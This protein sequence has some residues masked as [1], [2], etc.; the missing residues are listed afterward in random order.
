MIRYI[1]LIVVAGIVGAVL[2]KPKGRNP[3]LWFFLCAIIPL[4]VI[5]IALLP[6]VV[7]AG[8][9]KKCLNCSEII[10]ED[11]TVCKYCGMNI[12]KTVN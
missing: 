2:A 12:F 5:A 7:A 3:I 8:I 9:N 4:L 6:A 10:K 11:A 1:I